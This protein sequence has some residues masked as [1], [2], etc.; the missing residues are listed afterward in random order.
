MLRPW[1]YRA[2]LAV[3][4]LALAG[5]S[6]CGSRS[7]AVCARAECSN[8]AFRITLED[9]TMVETCCPRCGLHYL[10][11]EKRTAAKM[12]V[13]D[14]DTAATL[15]A[16]AAVY[17]V[18]SDVTPCRTMHAGGPPK[19]DRGCCLESTWD[20]CVP[21]VLAFATPSRAAAFVRA[22]GGTV[23]GFAGLGSSSR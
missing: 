14:F 6:S 13:R 17:V 10:E 12:T 22:H 15:D 21:S 5:A 7:C 19:D 1:T 16:G 11:R 18:G 9:G 23:A 3:A 20:R 2:A 8:L 4:L